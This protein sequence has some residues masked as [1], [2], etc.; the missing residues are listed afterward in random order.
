MWNPA[1]RRIVI[2]EARPGMVA[3]RTLAHPAPG[4]PPLLTPG[5]VLT[6]QLLAQLHELGIYD[7]W[8]SDPGLE[9]FVDLSAGQPQAAQR[10]M[11]DGLHSAVLR[12]AG[13]WGTTARA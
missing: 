12:L 9:F 4:N 13:V 10:R 7:L 2:K 6:V 1:M 11:A 3:S 8:V 5:T